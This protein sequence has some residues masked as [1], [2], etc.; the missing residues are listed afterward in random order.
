MMGQNTCTRASRVGLALCLLLVPAGAL[1]EEDREAE[2]F[3]GEKPKPA[4]SAE[5][6]AEPGARPGPTDRL[7]AAR[8]WLE[9]GAELY[10]RFQY[11]IVDEGSPEDF[12]LESPNLLHVYLDGRPNEELRAFARGRLIYDP[13]ATA[14]AKD[15]FGSPLEEFRLSLDQLWLKLDI[16]RTAFL[17]IGRQPIRWGSGR[18][19]NPTDFLN[20]QRRDPLAIFDERLGATLVKLHVPVESLGWNF[21]AVANLD[22]AASPRD[23]GGALRA[24]LLFGEVEFA[25]SA[26]ARADQ[27]MRLGFDCSAAVGPFDLRLESAVL[28]GE[29]K[30]Y[31]RG[32]SDLLQG[33]FPTKANREDDWIPQV[34]AGAEISILYS[35][36][37]SVIL[38]AEYFFNDFGYPDE[39]LYPYLA[40]QAAFVPFYVGR[41]YASAYVALPNPGEWNNTTFILSLLGNVSD[42]SFVTRLDYQVRLLTYLNLAAYASVHCGQGEFRFGF[43]VPSLPELPNGLRI[44]APRLELGL[45]LM[46]RM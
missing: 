28:H 42:L 10:F 21:Y 18:F 5:P 46:L 15:A 39:G 45:W 34:T 19:W 31:Y 23:V 9:L 17:T 14:G 25:L 41:H 26:A 29:T 11:D 7:D 16:A 6:A 36:Q 20:Q 3:G 2:M 38:G 43:E 13:T 40:T 37:D 12:R 1:A 44:V 4:K 35:E 32:H 30:P 22:G 33:I 8:D 27:P 24:E